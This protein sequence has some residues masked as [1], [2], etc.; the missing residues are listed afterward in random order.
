M[1]DWT[2]REEGVRMKR[3]VIQIAIVTAVVLAAVAGFL[4]FQVFS[5]DTPPEV[6]LSSASVDPSASADGTADRFTGTWSL[7]TTTGSLDDGSAT[8]AG[9]RVQEQLSTIGSHEAVGRTQEVSGSMTL[10]ATQVTALDISVDM[11]T[12][13]SDDERRDGQLRERGLETDAF[14]TATF[15]LSKPID[16]ASVPAAG[17]PVEAMA[18]GDLTLHGVTTQVRLP[19]QAQWT[20][21]RIEVAGSLDIAIADYGIEKP[22]GFIVLSVADTGTIEFHLLFERS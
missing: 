18:T 5:G 7:D 15:S 4:V 10:S 12:L 1:V 8:F 11:T 19:V 17:D 20:G 6:A 14:P 22:V 9:Y 2:L 16:M 21:D 3:R 13:A